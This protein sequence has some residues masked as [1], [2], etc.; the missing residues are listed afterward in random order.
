VP[1]PTFQGHAPSH[2]RN[3]GRY[4]PTIQFSSDAAQE[5]VSAAFDGGRMASDYGVMLPLE[6]RRNQADRVKTPCRNGNEQ[7]SNPAI[8]SCD[9]D[10]PAGSRHG[11]YLA[12]RQRAFEFSH[13][14]QNFR[15]NIPGQLHH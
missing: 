10:L 3:V 5:P 1:K 13:S 7:L 14:L 11:I 15:S 12:R 8:A 2:T 4:D 6:P 9:T